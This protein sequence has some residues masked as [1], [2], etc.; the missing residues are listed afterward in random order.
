MDSRKA[1]SG[2][3]LNTKDKNAFFLLP[4]SKRNACITRGATICMRWTC[5]ERA[6]FPDASSVCWKTG[7]PRTSDGHSG[8]RCAHRIGSQS[9][10]V[11]PR[12]ARFLLLLGSD[13]LYGEPLFGLILFYFLSCYIISLSFSEF[14]SGK[15]IV[16]KMFHGRE[17]TN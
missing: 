1:P 7:A 14:T 10:R 11:L 5:L 15:I 4:D 16:R 8:Q 9:S 13:L 12:T 6:H 2:L 17:K 3:F